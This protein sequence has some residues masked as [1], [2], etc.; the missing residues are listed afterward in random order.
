L[1][2]P[3]ADPVD[4][5]SGRVPLQVLAGEEKIASSYVGPEAKLQPS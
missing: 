1:N 3:L 5:A 4:E 2:H